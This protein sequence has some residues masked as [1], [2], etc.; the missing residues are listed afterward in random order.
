MKYLLDTNTCI[1]FIN[2]V[3]RKSVNI[4]VSLQIRT[5]QSAQ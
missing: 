3:R 5:S 1:R 2:G 4:C